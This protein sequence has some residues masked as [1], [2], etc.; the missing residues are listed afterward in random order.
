MKYSVS[1]SGASHMGVFTCEN[2]SGYIQ[3]LLINFSLLYL[4]TVYF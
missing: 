4:N 1:L 2:S 3:L